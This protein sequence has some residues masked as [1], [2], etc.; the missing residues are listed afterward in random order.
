[1]EKRLTAEE[2][3]RANNF[4]ENTNV[5]LIYD[6]L[7][8]RK[9]RS[10]NTTGVTGVTFSRGRYGAQIGFQGKKYNLGSFETLEE[11]AKVRRDAELE[12]FG[13][14]LDKYYDENPDKKP[15]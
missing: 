5:D 8:H 4:V 13:E 7:S 3:N 10:N 11:A 14:F 6:L 12:F 9:L 1:M 15:K 2:Y